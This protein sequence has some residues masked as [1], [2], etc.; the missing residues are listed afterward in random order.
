MFA[1]TGRPSPPNPP[2]DPTP[3]WKLRISGDNGTGVWYQ[4]PDLLHPEAPPLHT[5]LKHT[6]SGHEENA[7][8]IEIKSTKNDIKPNCQSVHEILLNR[9]QSEVLDFIVEYLQSAGF[10]TTAQQLING[11]QTT[12]TRHSSLTTSPFLRKL[13]HALTETETPSFPSSLDGSEDAA[14]PAGDPR[15]IVFETINS[16]SSLI[17]RSS[18]LDRYFP[19]S[20]GPKTGIIRAASCAAW[21]HHLLS[22]QQDAMAVDVFL[23]TFRPTISPLSLWRYLEGKYANGENETDT[24]LAKELQLRKQRI[25]LFI[26]TWIKRFWTDFHSDKSLLD[27]LL[28]FLY[29]YHSKFIPDPSSRATLQ[30]S[31]HLKSA[32]NQL[33]LLTSEKLARHDS[34]SAGVTV[35]FPY[36]PVRHFSLGTLGDSSLQLAEFLNIEDLSLVCQ[37]TLQEYKVYKSINPFELLHKAWTT[38]KIER[39]SV[40]I[41]AMIGR[42]NSVS[43]W[44]I[45]LILT[46]ATVTER[47]NVISKWIRCMDIAW[48]LNNFHCVMEIL[49]G[50]QSFAVRSLKITADSIPSDLNSKLQDFSSRMSSQS[51]SKEYRSA[52]RNVKQECCVPHIGMFLTDLTFI[53]DFNQDT[54]TVDLNGHEKQLLNIEKRTMIFCCIEEFLQFQEHDYQIKYD[55]VISNFI[56]SCLPAIHSEEEFDLMSKN[57]AAQ[58]SK[59]EP[60]RSKLMSS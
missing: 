23:L 22:S 47:V 33:E 24:V 50:L 19:L 12:R 30:T 54:V 26:T 40:N 25:V 49:S 1:S 15:D 44:I 56:L 57:L 2:L 17:S 51:S 55:P 45:Q 52:L 16:R 31:S 58:A 8:V 27:S 11:T 37:M 46:A 59:R 36:V 28:F 32:L 3:A 42:L 4:A 18:V 5:D 35:H 20:S 14:V 39:R 41:W 6:L 43:L 13:H 38:P 7:P 9:H 48:Q 53:E 10:E 34:C 60:S 21:I 29:Q